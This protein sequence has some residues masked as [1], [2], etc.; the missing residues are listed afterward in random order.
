M[1]THFGI[2]YPPAHTNLIQMMLT[3][4]LVGLSFEV[5]DSYIMKLNQKE[6]KPDAKNKFIII[7]Q[8]SIVEVFHYVFC[9]IGILTGPYFKY[10][11]YW[12]LFNRDY[13]KK[14]A[15]INLL[16]KKKYA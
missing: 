7:C 15:Y 1:T 12:D 3:L 16:L 2:P 4:K 13:W 5:H 6:T 8:P 14:A 9:Y 11:T 10:Q